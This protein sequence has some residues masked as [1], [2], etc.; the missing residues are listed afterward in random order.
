MWIHKEERKMS[1]RMF[2][3]V[4]GAA[5]GVAIA[6]RIA[7]DVRMVT[8]PTLVHLMKHESTPR[9]AADNARVDAVSPLV[10][11]LFKA[12]GANADGRSVNAV[13]GVARL[14]FALVESNETHLYTDD[15]I[16]ARDNIVPGNCDPREEELV[17]F[18]ALQQKFG[19]A[20]FRGLQV[21][22]WCNLTVGNGCGVSGVSD[23]KIAPFGPYGHTRPGAVFVDTFGLLGPGARP[24]LLMAHEIGHFLGL[25]HPDKHEHVDFD[26][27]RLMHPR[28]PGPKLLIPDEVQLARAEAERLMS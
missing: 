13:W 17:R 2:L 16:H 8:I 23:E 28:F 12:E 4:A 18:R 27:G 19:R 25:Q 24:A 26:S 21:F 7:A 6:D 10:P 11:T 1:R 20:D 15:D 9:F 5:T 3:G 22:V 14:S